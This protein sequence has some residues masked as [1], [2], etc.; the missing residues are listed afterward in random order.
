MTVA[1]AT[2]PTGASPQAVQHHYDL[3]N[4]F[5]A[6]WLDPTRTY[7][8][9]LWQGD[10]DLQQAQLNKIDWILDRA[11]ADG[12]ASLLDVG[13]G[14]GALLRRATE[15][16]RA[17]RAVGLSLSA[18]QVAWI[19]AQRWPRLDARL[20]SWMDHVPDAPY[21][22][23]VSVGAFEHFARLDQTPAQKRAGY[24]DFFGFCHR[25]LAPGGRL[26]LQTIIY[27]N[28]DRSKFSPFFADKVFPESDLPHLHEIESACAGLFEVEA[29]R[30]DREHYARTARAWRSALRARRAEATARVGAE[31]VADYEKYLGL[32]VV[33]FH[34]GSMD[35]AR[36]G[37]RR[38]DGAGERH[39]SPSPA[40]AP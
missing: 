38:V 11:G 12:V 14:W 18:A 25:V 27:G 4:D 20:E 19:A 35:L 24:R 9:A 10:E 29:L 16:H 36:L 28:A 23:I 6:L 40:P 1:G 17:E 21:G 22:A 31:Q 8:C 13:C 7:S 34:T 37:L 26:A 5:F 30:R 2:R 33:G 32:L 15:R 3:G 39:A